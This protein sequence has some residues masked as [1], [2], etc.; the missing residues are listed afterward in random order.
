[1]IRITR[2]VPHWLVGILLALAASPSVALDPYAGNDPYWVLLH[3]PAVREE[4]KLTAAQRQRW[5]ALVDELDLRFF[6]LRNRPQKE[7]LAGAAEITAEARSQLK[8]LLQPPQSKRLAQIVLQKIGTHA[9]LRDEV[10]ERMKYSPAQ[11]TELEQL[12]EKTQ[13][14]VTALEQEVREGQP[15]QPREKKYAQLKTEEHRQIQDLLKPE[16]KSAWRELFGPT[17]SLA[18]L[19]QPAFKTP[20]LIDTGDWING[21]PQQLKDL[22]GKVVVVHFYA[23]G[24]INCIHN[25]PTYHEWTE[26]FAGMDVAILGIHTP[27]TSSERDSANVRRKAAEAKF[28]FPVLIDGKNEN[29]NAWGNSMWP[30][31]Y[32]LDK[33]GYLRHFWPGE[34]KWQG[35]TGD[36]YLRERIEE[37]LKEQKS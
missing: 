34:L 9:L 16:Q 29:W 1:M 32:V 25:Y 23:C 21:G 6:P 35:A 36:E 11:R 7:A 13:S 28:T 22:R 2:L 31:V 27:E 33:R 18:K 14:A 4:L 24:C 8:A 15:R 17:F 3:E 30:S 26:H 37:L 20:E 5:Q 10:A 12:L 19:G